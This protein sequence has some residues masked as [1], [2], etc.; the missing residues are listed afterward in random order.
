MAGYSPIV[1]SFAALKVSDETT[2]WG[3]LR[4]FMLCQWQRQRWQVML[5]LGQYDTI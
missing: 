2:P 5:A 1:S 3:N 4:F